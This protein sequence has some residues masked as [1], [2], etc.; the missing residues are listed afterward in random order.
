[1][2]SH[3]GNEFIID[4]I[5]YISKENE[6]WIMKISVNDYVFGL[7]HITPE[8][9]AWFRELKE[10]VDGTEIIEFDHF[11]MFS[12]KAVDVPISDDPVYV[13][14]NDEGKYEKIHLISDDRKI[15]NDLYDGNFKVTL[16]AASEARV[17][18]LEDVISEKLHGRIYSSIPIEDE[19]DY[20]IECTI[21][22][23]FEFIDG[24]YR[25]TDNV[26]RILMESV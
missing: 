10:A 5:T 22:N 2:F 23:G 9:V 3:F 21:P 25:I 16:I 4:N 1:M 19:D 6:L 18:Q 7:T 14:H 26:K 17:R 15:Y 11:Q 13:I 12:A 8:T 24:V 20:K